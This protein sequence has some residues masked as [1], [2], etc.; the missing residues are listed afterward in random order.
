MAD[1]PQRRPD[2]ARPEGDATG[3]FIPYKN[4]K[5]LIA[6]Y[7]G[8]FSLMPCIGIVPGIAG[9]VLG[10]MGLSYRR[11]HPETKGSVH[12]WIGIVFGGLMTLLWGGLIAAAL[13]S[14]F[15]F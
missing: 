5:A 4:P 6:Y 2:D 14:Q 10:V 12:A 15:Q 3:G 13:L 9:V 8:V 1:L 7:C 11:Q